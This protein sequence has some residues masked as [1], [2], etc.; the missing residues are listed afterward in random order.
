MQTMSSPGKPCPS[1]LL[2]RSSFSLLRCPHLQ[3][4][5]LGLLLG[6]GARLPLLLGDELGLPRVPQVADKDLVHPLVLHLAPLR[7]F[8]LVDAVLVGLAVLVVRCMV[9]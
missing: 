9:L 5:L 8:R 1:S 4:L 6:R 3:P 2:L 7:L